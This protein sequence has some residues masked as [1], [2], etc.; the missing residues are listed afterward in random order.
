LQAKVI[1]ICFSKIINEM[2]KKVN[3]VFKNSLEMENVFFS[4]FYPKLEDL[5]RFP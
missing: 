3:S 5:Y 1:N 2:N 4:K